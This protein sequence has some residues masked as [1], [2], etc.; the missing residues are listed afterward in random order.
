M[1]AGFVF[2]LIPTI[3]EFVTPQLVGGSEAYMFGNAI[4]DLFVAGFDWNYGAVLVDLPAARDRALLALSA[5]FLR[6]LR[7]DAMNDPRSAARHA[8]VLPAYFP[9]WCCSCTRRS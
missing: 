9:C 8:G 1:I 5:R 2:V 7:D 4:Q 6:W 3:G